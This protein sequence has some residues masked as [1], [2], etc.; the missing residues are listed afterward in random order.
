M[1]QRLICFWLNYSNLSDAFHADRML[2]HG[3]FRIILGKFAIHFFRHCEHRR[4]DEKRWAL[5]VIARRQNFDSSS[6]RHPI[7]AIDQI[8]NGSF[9]LGPV[10]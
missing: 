8:G 9:V 3:A 10:R 6:L 7:G 4:F 2:K 1:Q 5:R